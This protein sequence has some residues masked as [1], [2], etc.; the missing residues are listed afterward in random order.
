MKGLKL[1]SVALSIEQLID[2][3]ASCIISGLM[4]EDGGQKD[5]V[6]I[7]NRMRISVRLGTTSSLFFLPSFYLLYL[8]V[9]THR[10][11]HALQQTHIC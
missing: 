6:L 10:A 3:G 1:R 11:L 2:K 8:E 4:T 7:D 5:A 9:Y